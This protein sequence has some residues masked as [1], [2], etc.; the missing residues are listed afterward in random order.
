MNGVSFYLEFPFVVL[1]NIHKSGLI[2]IT[3]VKWH[4][5]PSISD[6]P[7]LV[8]EAWVYFLGECWRSFAADVQLELL[9]RRLEW[10]A[11]RP[12]EVMALK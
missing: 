10:L 12:S 1:N 8:L 5:F 9:Q 4:A 2:I 11:Q 6:H 7:G 3:M